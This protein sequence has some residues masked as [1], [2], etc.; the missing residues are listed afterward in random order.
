MSLVR[1]TL[2]T[3]NDYGTDIKRNVE[4][5]VDTDDIKVTSLSSPLLVRA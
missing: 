3:F 2:V 1:Y 5:V 4:V